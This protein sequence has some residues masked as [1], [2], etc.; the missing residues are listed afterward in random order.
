M[1]VCVGER[2]RERGRECE[3]DRE[4]EEIDAA[5]SIMEGAGFVGL[6]STIVRT[7]T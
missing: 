6:Y 1:G 3:R 4:R 7:L 5:R 2:E